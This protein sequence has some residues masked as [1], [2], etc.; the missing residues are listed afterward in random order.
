MNGKV[1]PWITS[2][3]SIDQKYN[4]NTMSLSKVHAVLRNKIGDT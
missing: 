2:S 3:K 4:K 1:I